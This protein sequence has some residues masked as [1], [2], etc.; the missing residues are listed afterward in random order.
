MP[1]EDAARDHPQHV[2]SGLGVPAPRAGRQPRRRR[3]GQSAVQQGPQFRGRGGRVQVQ[4]HV[5]LL[6]PGQQ[7]PESRVV[8]ER[9]IGAEG[10]VHDPAGEAELANRPGQLAGRRRRISGRQGGE[11]REPVRMSTDRAGQRVV[12]LPRPVRAGRPGEAL[13]RRRRVR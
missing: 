6:E 13:R 5:Q 1:A 2:Q 3:A 10:A 8:E 9:P 4:R 11:A 12:G 7:L